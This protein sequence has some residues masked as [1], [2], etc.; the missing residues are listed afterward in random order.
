M[1]KPSSEAIRKEL[2]MMIE[3]HKETVNK[4]MTYYEKPDENESN[5][6]FVQ[7]CDW[8]SEDFNVGFEQGYARGLEVALNSIRT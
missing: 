1:E 3:S 7:N 5:Y 4:E 8:E 2:G 6:E